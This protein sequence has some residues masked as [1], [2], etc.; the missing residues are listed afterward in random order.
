MKKDYYLLLEKCRIKKC[1]EEKAMIEKLKKYWINDV[2]NIIDDLRNKKITK[3]QF[4][5][6]NKKIDDKYYKSIENIKL[7]QCELD[8]CYEG[9]KYIIHQLSDKINYTKKDIYNIKEYIN[10]LKTH[11]YYNSTLIDFI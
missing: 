5:A 2:S 10:I 1:K 9:V 3:T 8:K 4:I 11:S 6:K 7:L